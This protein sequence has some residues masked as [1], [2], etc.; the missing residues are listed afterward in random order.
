VVVGEG[1]Y[2]LVCCFIRCG[3]CLWGVCFCWFWDC[4]GR[5]R[6][7]ISG[8]GGVGVTFRGGLGMI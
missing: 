7:D 4:G 3:G 6:T 2:F 8:G 1:A 5:A